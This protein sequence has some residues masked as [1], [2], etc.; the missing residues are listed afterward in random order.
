MLLDMVE[1]RVSYTTGGGRERTFEIDRMFWRRYEF[2][3]PPTHNT[4]GGYMPQSGAGGAD[5]KKV[6]MMIDH[7][8]RRTGFAPHSAQPVL[9]P[10]MNALQKPVFAA[11]TFDQARTAL[12]AMARPAVD[13]ECGVVCKW[14]A[15]KFHLLAEERP[16]N[17]GLASVRFMPVNNLGKVDFSAAPPE[18]HGQVAS[19]MRKIEII[20]SALIDRCDGLDDLLAERQDLS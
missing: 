11:C 7:W 9:R 10:G 13:K 5:V 3:V 17:M 15:H 1:Q 4:A 14:V 20:K 2:S 18:E 12:T 6:K 19:I 8:E 16:P